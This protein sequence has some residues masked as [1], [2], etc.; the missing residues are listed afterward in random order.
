MLPARLQPAH[1]GHSSLLSYDSAGRKEVEEDV[2]RS[3]DDVESDHYDSCD[4]N[5]SDFAD[6]PDYAWG[7]KWSLGHAAT[8]EAMQMA[9]ERVNMVS[10]S[11]DRVLEWN[12]E[13]LRGSRWNRLVGALQCDML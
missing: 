5:K 2:Q 3:D 6:E 7:F 13:R 12:K 1:I 8:N 4:G 10:G 9:V 11:N